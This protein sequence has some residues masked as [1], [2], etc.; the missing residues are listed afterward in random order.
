[1]SGT[2]AQPRFRDFGIPSSGNLTD[3]L[4]S[5]LGMMVSLLHATRQE[6]NNLQRNIALPMEFCGK[7]NKQLE[8]TGR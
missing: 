7:K 2:C 5:F 4:W 6:G 8:R 1:M 3:E